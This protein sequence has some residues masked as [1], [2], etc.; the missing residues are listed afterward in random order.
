MLLQRR[1]H[2]YNSLKSNSGTWVFHFKAWCKTLASLHFF[3]LDT[4]SWVPLA[5]L[6]QFLYHN[7]FHFRAK[8]PWILSRSCTYRLR[9]PLS[10]PLDSWSSRLLGWFATWTICDQGPWEICDLRPQ[11]IRDLQ[12]W[13]ICDLWPWEIYNLWPWSIRDLRPRANMLPTTSVNQRLATLVNPQLATSS[14]Y[15]FGDL[16]ASWEY[17]FSY[18]SISWIWPDSF[19]L[20]V[21]F[22]GF[23]E[24]PLALQR[25]SLLIGKDSGSLCKQ[26][27]HLQSHSIGYTSS[28]SNNTNARG[29]FN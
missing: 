18:I 10:F 24:N 12:P 13:E 4:K 23:H 7:G 1:I 16:W 15:S 22:L 25:T 27:F 20:K 11:E 26:N 19:E 17:S 6:Q 9:W 5:L 29:L 8:S 3:L 21:S 2:V 14:K 28:W